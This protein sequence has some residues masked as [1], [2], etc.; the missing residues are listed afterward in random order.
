MELDRTMTVREWKEG[1]VAKG[2]KME[3]KWNY[4]YYVGKQMFDSVCI[5]FTH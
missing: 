5:P 1:V 3:L 2:L 4:F